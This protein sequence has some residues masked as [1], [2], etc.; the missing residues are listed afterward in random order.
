MLKRNTYGLAGSLL[1]VQRNAKERQKQ[2]CDGIVKHIKDNNCSTM[3]ELCLVSM[4]CYVKVQW[5]QNGRAIFEL[6]SSFW[7][8]IK[9]ICELAMLWIIRAALL[10]WCTV[11]VYRILVCQSLLGGSAWDNTFIFIYLYL[12]KEKS[13]SF[14][15]TLWIGEFYIVKNVQVVL[16][17]FLCISKCC[18]YLFLLHYQF[19]LGFKP[20]LY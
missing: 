13:C 10:F 7:F 20:Q 8:N 3:S 19:Y 11:S 17:H 9:S 2:G 14:N 5:L 4:L 12:Q 1:L 16:S 18:R 6:V 15:Q